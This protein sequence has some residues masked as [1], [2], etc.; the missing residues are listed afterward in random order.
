MAT[1][2]AGNSKSGGKTTT[3]INL[4]AALV[5]R[6]KRVCI[7]DLDPSTALSRW[8]TG[9]EHDNGALF[10]ALH[11]RGSLRPVETTTEGLWLIP[12]SP[13]LSRIERMGRAPGRSLRSALGRLTGFDYTFID[14]PPG[15]SNLAEAALV[16]ADRVVIPVEPSTL[17]I[18]AVA[19]YVD[20]IGRIR[21]SSNKGLEIAGVILVRVR[22]SRIA[23]DAREL[24]EEHFKGLVYRS[25]IREAVRL[26][27]A[28]SFGK[29]ILQHARRSTVAGDFRDLASEFLRR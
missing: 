9:R 16:A 18:D 22:R 3:T 21:K 25:E 7:V 13:R 29:T 11:G 15:N 8:A 23:R 4:A 14:P 28:P 17:S 6:G 12:G 5:E 26:R 1:Y 10:D 2:V 19:G 27:E 20:T 24:L